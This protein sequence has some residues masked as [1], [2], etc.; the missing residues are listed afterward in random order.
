MCPSCLTFTDFLVFCSDLVLCSFSILSVTMAPSPQ[1][2]AWCFTVNNPAGAEPYLVFDATISYAIWQLELG[3]HTA[4]PHLQGYLVPVKKIRMSSVKKIVGLERAHLEPA[5]GNS[6]QNEAYC[7]KPEGRIAG[8]WVHGRKSMKGQGARADVISLRDAIKG[9]M[10]R[11]QILEEFPLEYAKYP[12]FVHECLDE[13]AAAPPSPIR[14]VVLR[15]WQ[16]TLVDKIIVPADDRTVHWIVDREGNKGKTFLSKYLV[17]ELNAFYCPGGKHSDLAY[18]YA[19]QPIIVFDFCR[20]QE[21][22]VPYALIES[23]K[24]GLIFS[25]KYES[26]MKIIRAPHVI[27]FANFAP[28]ESKLSADRWWIRY[29][30][31]HSDRLIEVGTEDRAPLRPIAV[32]LD[33]RYPN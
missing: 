29:V 13:Y 17:Q 20:D 32:H 12:K 2:A 19:Y 11:K 28:D 18:L 6:D 27:C 14:D 21:E 8:P 4:T 26:R 31:R 30:A 22:R 16:Q 9:G 15:V 3:D 1:S 33:H 10:K 24:N 25:A 23:F 7:S 5:H